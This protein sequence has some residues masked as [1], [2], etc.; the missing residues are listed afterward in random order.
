MKKLIAIALLGVLSLSAQNL[1]LAQKEADFRYLASL[2]ASLYAMKDWKKQVFQV[3]PVA[4]RPWL[5]KVAATET[6]LDFYDVCAEYIAVLNDTHVSFILPSDFVA[7]LNFVVDLYDDTL[8]IDTINR[9]RLPLARFPF[10]IGDELVSIDGED[11]RTMVD[12]FRRYSPQGNPR[13]SRRMAAQRL[14]IR[15][16]SR[17]PHAPMVGDEATV[18][19]RRQ[20]GELETF[21]I[22][23]TKTGT[24]LEVGAVTSPRS[25]LKVRAAAADSTDLLDQIHNFRVSADDA[26]YVTG[27]GARN[28][29]FLAGLPSTFTRRLGGTASDFFYSG[30]FRYDDLRIGYLRIPNFAP[31]SLALAVSQLAAEVAFFKANTDGLVVDVMRNT[32][33]GCLLHIAATYFHT[34]PFPSLTE[35]LNPFWLRM[36]SLRNALIQAKASG[37]SQE[38][39]EQYETMVQEVAAANAEGR[40]TRPLPL[41]TTRTT[42]E[43]AKNV[44]GEVLAYDKPVMVLTDDFSTSA[45]DLFSAMMQDSGRAVLYGMRTNGAGG[46]TTGFDAGIF[47]ES[48]A[49]VTISVVNR[50]APVPNEDYPTAPYIENIGIRPDLTVDYMTKENLLNNG[51]PFVTRFTEAM[52]EYIRQ[53]R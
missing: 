27:Y 49:S 46:A 2:Y 33:G 51:A 26:K 39:I 30:V 18:V 17:I 41:C 36:T 43:P 40:L 50:I 47:S 42:E 10:V 37:A 29:V 53:R 35:Q 4:I 23:W 28:P 45:A 21:S 5:E 32:G 9:T 22:P 7:Q 24:P 38:I 44:Y 48:F 8:L 52:A 11:A 15:S 3:D 34:Q 14:T 20:N 1:T 19:I 25:M 31:P 6:D 12:R 16:Q 13:A